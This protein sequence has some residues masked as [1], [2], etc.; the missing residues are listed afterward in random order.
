MN[1][2]ELQAKLADAPETIEFAEVMAL[3]DSLYE[4]HPVAFT[5]GDQYNEAGQNNG[6]CKLF[7][8]ARLQGLNEQE[9]LSCFGAF[10]R[11]DVL[12]NPDG[13]DHQ[14][15][16]NFIKTGWLGIEFH[17]DALSAKG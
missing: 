5:N 6:S 17:G 12:G 11:D 16:R 3:V 2:K 9:T 13:D 15:I 14:N 10:Y 8:F 1:I 7:A 4:F